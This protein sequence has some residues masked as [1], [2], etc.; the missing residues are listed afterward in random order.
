MRTLGQVV[1]VRLEQAERDKVNQYRWQRNP[2]AAAEEDADK[3]A[4]VTFADAARWV[5]QV[6]LPDGGQVSVTRDQ[7]TAELKVGE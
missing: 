4:V 7:P 6:F 5:A 2:E 3:A 1:T